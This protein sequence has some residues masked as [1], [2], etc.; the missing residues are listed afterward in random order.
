MQ[1]NNKILYGI[2]AVLVL[3]IAGFLINSW[4]VKQAAEKQEE[5]LA[6]VQKDHK[7]DLK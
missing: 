2:I 7:K 5:Q 3:I 1:K 6:E 4:Y